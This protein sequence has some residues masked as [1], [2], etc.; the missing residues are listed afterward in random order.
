M[1]A[2]EGDDD[3]SILNPNGPRWTIESTGAT[4][5]YSNATTL[6]AMVCSLLPH[7]EFTSHPAPSYDTVSIGDLGGTWFATTLTLPPIVG[8]DE[9]GRTFEGAAMQSKRLAKA[10]VAFQACQK[11][12]GIGHLDDHLLPKRTASIRYNI[13]AEGNIITFERQ[14]REAEPHEQINDLG[15]ML[16][17]D[18]PWFLHPISLSRKDGKDVSTAVGLITA[19]RMDIDE[20]IRLHGD[21]ADDPIW[22]VN[23]GAPIPLEWSEAERERQ[24]PRLVDITRCGG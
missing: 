22:T 2:G 17:P 14:T 23:V 21:E 12:H 24:R 11:L 16:D 6:L 7:E 8:L 4:L 10:S 9:A 13:D 19:A 1:L 20:P 5:T 18:A 15:P 3:E